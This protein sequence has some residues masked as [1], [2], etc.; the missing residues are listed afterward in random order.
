VRAITMGQTHMHDNNWAGTPNTLMTCITIILTFIAKFG[1]SDLAAFFAI[2]AALS[3]ALLNYAK[4]REMRK[5]KN[6]PND[7]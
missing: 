6:K 3:T 5:D 1:L 2:I 7:N 4:Y